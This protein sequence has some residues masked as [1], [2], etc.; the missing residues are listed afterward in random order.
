MLSSSLLNYISSLS[1]T[2]KQNISTKIVDKF[3]D[4]KYRANI[5]IIEKLYKIYTKK[6][7]IALR[8]WK[9]NSAS[10]YSYEDIQFKPHFTNFT[11]R[12]SRQPMASSF[13]NSSSKNTVSLRK[14]RNMNAFLE[15]QE[16]YLRAKSL[17]KERLLEENEIFYQ[18]QCTFSPSIRN[19]TSRLNTRSSH[20][21]SKSAF[22]KLY[23]DGLLRNQ[24]QQK[25][26]AEHIKAI[27]ETAGGVNRKID[28][29][30]IE[31]LYNDYKLKKAKKKS[32]MR[33]IDQDNGYTFK[34]YINQGRRNYNNIESHSK[35]ISQNDV[36][37]IRNLNSRAY[38]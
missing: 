12:K 19:N 37:C 28:T 24:K 21:K 10:S 16:E 8:Q 20:S 17:N 2:E 35:T 36:E 25:N 22:E 23:E 7:N 3:F 1:K 34:P 31:Q 6:L 14:P 18:L 33:Q 13:L 15:R 27:K 9:V 30:K 4:N 29:K 38:Y 11:Y 5:N 32:L 26:I